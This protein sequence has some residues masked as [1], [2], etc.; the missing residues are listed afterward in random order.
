MAKRKLIGCVALLLLCFLVAGCWDR[1]ELQDRNFVLAVAIDMADDGLKLGIDPKEALKVREEE[2]F[3]QPDGRKRYRLSLQLLKFSSGE[4]GKD[5]AKTYAISNTGESFFEM[6]RDML[7]QSSKSLWFEHLQVIIISEAVLR[8]TGLAEIV[9]F[10]K[11]DSEMRS[12]IKVYVTPGTARSLIEYQPPSK[13]AGGMFLADLIRLHSRNNHIAGA[14]TDLGYTV[15]YLDL[16]SNVLLPR[17]E[18][19][20]KVVKLGGSAVF[21]KDKF[22]GYVDGYAIAGLKFMYGTEESA[23]VATEC[24][25]HPGHQMAFELFRDDTKLI[26][27]VEGDTIY[28]TVDINMYGNLGEI[29]GDISQDDTLDPQYIHRLEIAFAEEI[30]QNVLYADRVFRKEMQV[31]TISRFAGKLKAYEP[32][33]W[34]KVQDQWDEIYPMIPIIISVNVTIQKVGSHK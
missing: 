23:I 15:Q 6:V 13:E 11:R 34:A 18:I 30:K 8:Q 12:R 5:E 33:T 16:R 10:F 14:R 26:P 29:Q 22:I 27:H 9:D 3:V 17:I 20:D 25:D 1:R 19:A 32:E 7:G 2:T 4:A 24:P 28:F 21:K 31:D